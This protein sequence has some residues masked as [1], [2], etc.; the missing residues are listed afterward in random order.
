MA[1]TPEE[2]N[3]FEAFLQRREEER[4]RKK[5]L[6][7]TIISVLILFS[8]ALYGLFTVYEGLNE[9][10]KYQNRK[11]K[12]QV[13]ILYSSEFLKAIKDYCRYKQIPYGKIVG[14][15]NEKIIIKK[16]I[17]IHGLKIELKKRIIDS[18]RDKSFHYKTITP[19]EILNAISLYYK[20]E[21][22]KFKRII[23][24]LSKEYNGFNFDY[25]PLRIIVGVPI[26]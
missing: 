3:N 13:V 11:Y 7:I 10:Y 4:K 12:D 24:Q 17:F 23:G 6:F 21:N 19:K 22:Y 15:T 8:G 1:D 5:I 14:S 18:T 9:R 2:Q 16:R 25:K 20:S 26:E